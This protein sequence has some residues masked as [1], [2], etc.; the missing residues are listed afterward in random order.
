[1]YE[2]GCFVKGS[3]NQSSLKVEANVPT[4]IY[5]LN[6]FDGQQTVCKKIIIK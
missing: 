6:L 4:G 1:M 3:A 5:F 2:A